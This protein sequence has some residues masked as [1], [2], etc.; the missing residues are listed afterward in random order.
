MQGGA[1]AMKDFFEH[2]YNKWQVL[3]VST[4]VNVAENIA[5]RDS[6]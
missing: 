2:A 3:D 6:G 4:E 5:Y 1:F